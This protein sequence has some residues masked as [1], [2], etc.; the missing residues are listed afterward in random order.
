L[1]GVF[2]AAELK[3]ELS[4]FEQHKLQWLRSNPGEFVVITG[5][6]VTGFYPDYESAFRAGLHAGIKG[7]FL[8]KQVWA[9]EPVYLI[10]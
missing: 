6:E 2:L 7:D 3:T 9:E 1:G 5:T 10:Y 4:V 8:V